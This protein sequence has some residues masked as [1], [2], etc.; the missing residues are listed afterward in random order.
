MNSYA[1]VD[2]SAFP[3]VVITF[4]GEKA[5]DDNFTKYL[6]DVLALYDRKEPLMLIFDATTAT[7]PNVKYQKQQADWLKDQ[8]DLMQTYCKGTAYV[9]PNPII[10]TVLKGIFVF[11]TQPVPYKVVKTL[12]EA[13][14]WFAT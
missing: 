6:Q 14:A 1:I 4:T 3:E 13:R 12:E 7:T 11:Q 8:K 9:I 5:D 10:R 2:D